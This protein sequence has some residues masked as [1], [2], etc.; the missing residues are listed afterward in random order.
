MFIYIIVNNFDDNAYVGYHTGTNLLTRWREH[1]RS[2][3]EG[4]TAY[5]HN[6]MRKHGIHQFYILPV[7]SGYMLVDELK[8][9]EQYY[10]KCFNTKWPFG[11]NLTQGGDGI[12]SE[13]MKQLWKVPEYVELQKAVRPRYN[14]GQFKKGYTSPRKGGH[15]ED[16]SPKVRKLMSEKAKKHN[17]EIGNPRKGAVVDQITR[18]KISAANKGREAYNKCNEEIR[19]QIVKLRSIGHSQTKI[20]A[21]VGVTQP[22]VSDILIQNGFRTRNSYK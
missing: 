11:Y 17:D 20:A 13:Y 6:S 21:I 3:K 4:S 15:R 9:L 22:C 2:V 18:E 10:I 12:D 14:S 7:W 5:L 16:I 19:N 8:K 1:L